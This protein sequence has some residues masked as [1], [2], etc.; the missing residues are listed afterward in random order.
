MSLRVLRNETNGSLSGLGRKMCPYCEWNQS[1]RELERINLSL[2]LWRLGHGPLAQHTY[3]AWQSSRL[4]GLWTPGPPPELS[5]TTGIPGSPACKGP[6]EQLLSCCNYTSQSR[7]IVLHT[8]TY[9]SESVLLIAS[10]LR[11]FLC[12]CKLLSIVH[13]VVGNGFSFKIPLFESYLHKCTLR[14]D[15]PTRFKIHRLHT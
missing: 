8:S 13:L 3:F 6:V 5:H 2:S 12:S 15:T 1:I 14:G 4:A 11:N 10:R 9:V 7:Q